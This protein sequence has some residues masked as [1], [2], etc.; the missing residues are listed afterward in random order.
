MITRC[1][2]GVRASAQA[3]AALDRANRL[4]AAQRLPES[5]AESPMR[6]SLPFRPRLSRLAR[7]TGPPS[8]VTTCVTSLAICTYLSRGLDSES[9]AGAGLSD[10]GPP[11]LEPGT[12][13]L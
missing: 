3:A 4:L 1:S 11:G 7:I 9:P 6:A 10:V 5:K 2:R 8:G 12:Y 13:R